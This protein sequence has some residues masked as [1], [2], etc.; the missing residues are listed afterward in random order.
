MAGIDSLIDPAAEL[1]CL[2]TGYQ[3]TEGP[4]WVAAEDALYFSDIPGDA[5][6]RWTESGGMELAERPTFK[7]NGMALDNDG[8]LLVCEQVSSFLVRLVPGAGRQLVACEFEGRYLNSPNDVVTRGSDGSIYFTDPDYGRWNDWI[9]QERS[10]DGLGFRGV[11]RVPPGGGELE[12]VVD[13]EEFDQPNGLCFSP[14]ETLLYV[15]DSSARNVKVFD[16]A[17]D[18]SLGTARLLADNIGTGVPGSGNV[19]GMECDELGNV[20]VTGPGG[21][22]VLT[23]AGDHL[24]TVATPEVCGSHCWG[25]AD[26]RTLFL[27]TSTSVHMVRTLVGP[28]PLP[29]F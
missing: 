1:T 13:R 19:D 21:I 4:V 25:G 29:P 17:P 28:A 9:G 24:G 26:L 6:W 22:W 20:W 7:G 8:H 18:G 5:R 12:L 14:D 11:F 3:F 27:M 2:G 15:N 16:V 10:R 23:P